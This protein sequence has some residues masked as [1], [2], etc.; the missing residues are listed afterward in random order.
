MSSRLSN[1]NIK[2][3]IKAIRLNNSLTQQAFAESIGV[4]Q[5]Y[6]SEL[7]KGT[8]TPSETCLIAISYCYEINMD[9]LLSGK[10]DITSPSAKQT[11]N[12]SF[13]KEVI[14]AVETVLDQESKR[15]VP[16]KKA[17]LVILI[18]ESLLKEE[19]GFRGAKRDK[20]IRGSVSK[21]IRLAS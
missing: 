4:S 5:G 17:E 2:D 6:L 10:G 8:K 16:D 21:F 3:R 20:F 15:L 12:L 19:D 14:E 11:L 13:L 7:E 9:W 18:Y 1:K